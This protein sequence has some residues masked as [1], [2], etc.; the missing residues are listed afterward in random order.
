MQIVTEKYTY[1]MLL[2]TPRIAHCQE[3]EYTNSL[4]D[5]MHSK[6]ISVVESKKV[7]VTAGFRVTKW[8]NNDFE[9]FLKKIS[10]MLP[11]LNNV[12]CKCRRSTIWLTLVSH[13][14]HPINMSDS[15]KV[16]RDLQSSTDTLEIAPK[17]QLTQSHPQTPTTFEL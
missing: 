14:I 10:L 15:R 17:R 9:Q 3:T 6:T 4:F 5:I 2:M 8:S 11:F 12:F 13:P 7:R 16:R 1:V